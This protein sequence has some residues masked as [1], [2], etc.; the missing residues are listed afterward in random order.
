MQY[1]F[2]CNILFF[3]TDSASVCYCSILFKKNFDSCC[4]LEELELYDDFIMPALG[5]VFEIYL[6]PNTLIFLL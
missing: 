2:R 4:T 5:T 6:Y 3:Y 1:C